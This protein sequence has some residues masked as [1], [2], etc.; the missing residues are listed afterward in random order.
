VRGLI[1]KVFKRNWAKIKEK[2]KTARNL[3]RWKGIFVNIKKLRGF[4]AKTPEPA[5]FDW[6]DSGDQI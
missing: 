3:Q 4:S 5:G 2:D 6:L 1:C